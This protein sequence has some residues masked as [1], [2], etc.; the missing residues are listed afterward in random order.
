MFKRLSLLI[1]TAA[2]LLPSFAFVHTNIGVTVKDTGNKFSVYKDIY[3]DDSKLSS[4]NI[5][6]DDFMDDVKSHSQRDWKYQIIDE[7]EDGIHYVGGHFSAAPRKKKLMSEYITLAAN[8]DA[9]YYYREKSSLGSKT[10]TIQIK[11]NKKQ[12]AQ[13][14]AYLLDYGKGPDDEYCFVINTPKKIKS[15]NGQVSS[16]GMSV[17]WDIKDAIVNETETELVVEYANPTSYV[18]L[19]VV[20]VMILGAVI[21]FVTSRKDNEPTEYYEYT[22]AENVDNPSNEGKDTEPVNE[23]T[24]DSSS[25]EGT[26]NTPSKESEDFNPPKERATKICPNCGA[27]LDSEETFCENCGTF[28]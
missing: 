10:V 26:E 15:S 8:S 17:K 6:R 12:S 19:I 2:M 14:V 13:L 11:P 20:I 1:L 16:D 28:I 4:M 7:N 21:S 22:R 18:I 9:E 3:A 27:V 25:K 23:E 5:T 24:P